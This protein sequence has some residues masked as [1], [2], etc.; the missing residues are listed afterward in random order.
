MQQDYYSYCTTPA[1]RADLG[2][3]LAAGFGYFGCLVAGFWLQGFYSLLLES[4]HFI[5]LFVRLS[6][7]PS[8]RT[9]VL[10]HRQKKAPITVGEALQ[11]RG[12]GTAAGILRLEPACWPSGGGSVGSGAN[13]HP[14]VACPQGRPQVYGVGSNGIAPIGHMAY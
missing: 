5:R 12:S 13:G 7:C 10:F 9:L 4:P 8:V 2:A 1:A 3:V 11:T 6:V 14:T